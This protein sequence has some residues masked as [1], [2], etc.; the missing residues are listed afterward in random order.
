MGE[1]M[2]TYETVQQVADPEATLLQFLQSTYDAAART[3]NWDKN[4]ECDLQWLKQ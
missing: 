3:G 4:L 1:F 2:L